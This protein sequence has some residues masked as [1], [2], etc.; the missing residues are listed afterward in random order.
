MG[1]I[2]QFAPEIYPQLY[3]PIQNVHATNNTCTDL[4]RVTRV[5]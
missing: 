5:G 2:I 3:E 1:E 4:V